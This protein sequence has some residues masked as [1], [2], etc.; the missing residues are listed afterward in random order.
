MSSRLEICEENEGEHVE[1]QDFFFEKIGE[2]VP[3]KSQ[4]DSQF[5]LR[6]PPSQPLVLSQRFQLLFLAHSSGGFLVAR[7]KDVIDLAKDIREKASSSSI[8][9]LSL[10]EVPIGKVHILALSTIDDTILAVSVAADIHFFSVS[11]LLNKDIKPCFS[12]SLPQSSFV[13][14]IRWRKKKDN[15]FLVLSDDRKLYH[16]TLAH[17]LKHVMDNVDAVEW[18]AKGAF[19]AVAKDNSLSILSSKFNEKLC[20]ALSFKSWVGD[21]NDDCTVKVDTIRWIHPDCIILG[22]FQFTRDA[23]EENYLVQVVKSKSGKI[24]DATSN[25]VVLS[26]SDLFAGLIDDIVPFGTGPYLYLS[27]LEQ[28]KLAIAANRKNTDQHIVLLSW[29]LGETGEASVVDIERDNWLPRIELQDNDDDNLIMGLCIDN[30]SVCGSVKVQL[31]VEEVRELSPCCVL[32]CLTLEGKLIMFQ[33]ASARENDV[34]PDV[35]ALSDKEEDTPAVVSAEMDPPELTY[36]EGEQKSEL[37]ALSLP[38]MDKGKTELLT[39]GSSDVN[40]SQM[41]VNSVTHAT[42]KLFHNDDIKTAVSLKNSQSSEAVGQQKPPTSMLYQEAG[43]Q[44]KLFFGGQGTNSGQSFLRTSQLEGPGN[45]VRDGS[46]TEAQKIPGFGS[47]T[48]VAKVSNDSLLQPS[49]ESIPKKFELVKEPV[50]EA[51]SIGLQSTSVKLWPNP[52]SQPFSSG[53]FMVSKES[54]ARASF[55]SPSNFQYN[56]SQSTRGAT[57]IPGS[58]VEK[59]SHL[60]DTT[61]ISVSVN[62][63]SGTPVDIGA[64]KFSLGAGNIESVPLI[65]GSQSSSLLNF[66]M[67]KSFNQK[68]HPSKDEYKSA[69]QS[70]MLKLEPQLL[71]QFGNIKEMAKEL[72]TLLESIEEAGGFRDVCTVFQRSSVEELEHGIAVLSKKCRS[73]KNVMDEQ[74]GKIQQHL[75]KTIQVLA[76]KIYIEGIIKQASDRQYWDLW[77]CQKLSSELELKQRHILKLNQDLTNQLIELERHFNTRELHKFGDDDGVRDGRRTFQSRFGPSRHVLSLH[78]LHSTMSSQLAAAE[79]LSECLSEQMAILSVQSPVKKQNVKEE[80]FQMIGIAHDA[81]FTSPHATKP[82]NKSKKLVISSGSSA[83]RNQSRR[84]QSCAL[85]SSDPEYSRRSRESLDQSWATFEPPKTT[86]KRM[87]LQES[88]NVKRSLLTDKQNFSPYASEESTSLFSK[89][90]KA[91]STTLHQSG[92]EVK[93]KIQ[94]ALPRQESETTVFRW[95]NNSSLLPP[96]YAGWKS[97]TVQTSNF[98]ALPSASGS[99]PMLVQNSSGETRSIP[100]AKLNSG[101]SQVER[102]NISSFNENEIQST[103]QFRPNLHQES[104]IS[105]VASLPKKSTDILNS[106]GKGI[107]LANSALGDVKHVSSTTKSTLFG[108]SNDNNSQFIPPAAV[109]ASSAPSAKVSQFN[110]VTSKIQPSEKV[111]Q[112]FAFSK[113]VEDS[114]SSI[115]SSSSRSFSSSFSTMTASSLTSVNVLS[116]ETSATSAP[117]FSFS[118]SFSAVPT[119]PAAQS[120]EP[121]SVVAVDANRKASSFSP[122]SVPFSAFVSSSDSLSIQPLKMPVPLPADLS[123]VSSSEIL[124]VEAQPHKEIHDLKKDGDPIIQAPPLQHELPATELSLKPKF[125]V[126]S[127][128]KSETPTGVLSGSQTS[129]IDL[130]SPATNLALNPQPPRPSTGDSLSAPSSISINTTNGKSRSLDLT[131]EDEMEEEAPETNQMTELGLGSLSSSGIGSTPNPTA[132]KPNPFGAPFGVV[133]T[134]AATSSFTSTVNPGELFRPASFSFQS[135]QPSQSA[136]PA[137]FGTFSGGFASGAPGQAPAQCAFGQPAQLGAGQQALGSVLGAFGQSRQLGTALPGSS[138]ASGSGFGGGFASPQSAAGFSNAAT[139]GGFAG[140]A[141][142]GGGFS[143]VASGGGFGVPAS[144]GGG[145]GSL[146][147]GG[148]AGSASCGGGFAGAAAGGTGGFAAPASGGGFAG[149]AGSGSGGFGVFSS[150]Q[151][152]AGFSAFGGGGGQTGKPPELFTQMRK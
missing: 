102:S 27:Y 38:L 69:I 115:F 105:Q 127:P 49:H 8:E 131:Q 72:D 13:K 80:L 12:T 23:K 107:V 46:Q 77:N 64:Q 89:E 148:V 90:L 42:D 134:S 141:S 16:G 96:N 59:P 97:S 17:P 104:S 99:Q 33:I 84:N 4:P 34:P 3:V 74:L 136:Q 79:Q 98:N 55:S 120:S 128:K 51:G 109:S 20:V 11:S 19:V 61:G 94:D 35:S 112:S 76:R 54:D 116:T 63:I 65:R 58:N 67:E 36:G 48:P 144:G 43:T 37:V 29:S 150:Q 137:S 92:N 110:V 108:S 7:T 123:P 106:D 117:K 53:K 28:S 39:N 50:G 145:F 87:L 15:S 2:P 66:A 146:A 140:L 151:R 147:S 62:K 82:S 21:S 114:S 101:A 100:V 118:T 103:L 88:A 70:R 143:G 111:S 26:F 40:L 10:V 68:L 45:K 6:S 30:V 132:P 32:I 95:A 149:A 126:S 122:S 121:S 73:W 44:Q 75:D 130:A 138:F 1:T 56:S 78:S 133:A 22:C 5:D 18:S 60:K 47:V 139:G 93:T 9:D 25:L 85:K 135:P 152:N 41:N 52:S 129:I 142:G 119:S 86:V 31:G 71:K 83:S 81:S 91:T 57:S 14:D 125:A 24:T 124:K 113:P